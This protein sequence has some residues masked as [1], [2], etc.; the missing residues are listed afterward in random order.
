MPDRANGQDSPGHAAS[1]MITL[2]PIGHRKATVR[3]D[4]RLR[5]FER[6]AKV[7]LCGPGLPVWIYGASAF[8]STVNHGYT[9][10]K[11]DPVLGELQL[12]VQDDL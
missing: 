2:H 4:G 9:V 11:P 6:L 1:L 5:T 3:L 7:G 10:L 8:A 12:H